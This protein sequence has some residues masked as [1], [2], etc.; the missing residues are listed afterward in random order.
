LYILRTSYP[1][2]LHDHTENIEDAEMF[3]VTRA[4]GTQKICKKLKPL[5]NS[6]FFT[7]NIRFMYESLIYIY[8]KKNK[9]FKQ[10]NLSINNF[11]LSDLKHYNEYLTNNTGQ[12]EGWNYMDGFITDLKN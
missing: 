2:L 10:E 6:Q 5:S 9:V 1:S 7:K 12:S 11:L 8:D 4:N 3:L